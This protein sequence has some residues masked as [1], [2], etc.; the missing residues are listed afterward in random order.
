[1]SNNI[2]LKPHIFINNTTA[3]S[4]SNWI[5]IDSRY[6]GAQGRSIFGR[7][8][9]IDSK[10]VFLAKT[11][12]PQ[13]N[14][15]GSRITATASQVEVTVTATIWTSANGTNFSAFFESPATHLRVIK[16]NA[17]GAATVVGII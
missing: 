6:S 1:M 14:S 17:S 12:V 4:T 8:T 3:A 10:I 16:A 13:F 15:D 2:V 9:D 7:R 11:Q 5:P